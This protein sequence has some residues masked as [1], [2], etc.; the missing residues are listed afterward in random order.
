MRKAF[1][2]DTH[3]C[4]PLMLGDGESNMGSRLGGIH[5]AGMLPPVRTTITRY[6]A[7]IRLTTDPCVE[8]SLFTQF[9]SGVMFQNQEI[10]HDS[11]KGLLHILMHG[12][13]VRAERSELNIGLLPYP[14]ILKP[15]TSDILNIDGEIIR[16]P[17]HKLGGEP[18][19][20]EGS[21]LVPAVARIRDDG[22]FLLFQIA[23]P[24][25]DDAAIDGSWPFAD[26]TLHVFSRSP[27]GAKFMYC[28]G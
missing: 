21:K 9:D 11:S 26:G 22:Y 23:F 19:L 20:E 16:F 6:F 3:K 1:F 12:A 24:D 13:S 25:R 17:H 7:T 18:F 8:V 4:R 2:E 28:W 10:M 27:L 15:E 5:P 14:I